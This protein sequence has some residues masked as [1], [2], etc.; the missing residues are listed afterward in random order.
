[1]APEVISSNYYT[2]K[3]D[4]F[5]FGIILWEIASREPPYRSKAQI[6]IYI[7]IKIKIDKTGA[8]VSVEVVSNNLRPTI[9]KNCPPQFADLM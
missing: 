2:E 9:P 8:A 4:V 7:K 3:A 6:E 1:M 5:S